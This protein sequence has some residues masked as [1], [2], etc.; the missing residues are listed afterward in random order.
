M[1]RPAEPA[2]SRG[3]DPLAPDKIGETL[4]AVGNEFGMLDDICSVTDHTRQDQLVVR[5]F[6]VAPYPPF[7]LMPD[8]AGLER[9][10]AGINGQH[11]LDNLAHRDVGDMR[12]VP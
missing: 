5:E 9:I 3:D 6:D 8:I 4:D 11:N 1:A 10:G 7:V 2:I 12:T